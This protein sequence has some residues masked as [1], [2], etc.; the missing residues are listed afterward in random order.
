[1]TEFLAEHQLYVVLS[2]VLLVWV[3]IAFYLF[4]LDKKITKLEQAMRKE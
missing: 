3:G 2:I 4:R 1:M